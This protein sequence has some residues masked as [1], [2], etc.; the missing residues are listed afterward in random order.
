M[1]ALRAPGH[2]PAT[3]ASIAS[4]CGRK[5]TKQNAGMEK[6]RPAAPASHIDGGVDGRGKKR[7]R[8][9]TN[10]EAVFIMLPESSDISL[11]KEL[12]AAAAAARLHVST[13]L[14]VDVD[15]MMH[16]TRPVVW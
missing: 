11:L 9:A 4:T 12:R 2:G 16:E 3:G 14:F 15:L 6:G 5:E 7:K 1:P 8:P 10:R 13:E